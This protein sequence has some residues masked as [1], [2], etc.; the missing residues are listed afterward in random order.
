MLCQ[1]CGVE[2]APRALFCSSCGNK[3][4]APVPSEAVV[5]PQ[6]EQASEQIVD[7]TTAPIVE[8]PANLPPET[9]A[10][11]QSPEA[12]QTTETYAPV[13]P[14]AFPQPQ[15]N[16]QPTAFTPP[17]EYYQPPPDQHSQHGGY[18]TQ[19]FI[20]D[21]YSRCM[22]FLF[23]RP[24]RVWGL[25]LMCILMSMLSVVF[26]I[27]PIVFIPILLVLKLGMV[28]TF[29]KGIKGEDISS[30][31]LFEGFGK[32]RFLRNAGGM[33]WMALWTLIWMPVPFANIIKIYS[34]RFVPYIMLN[35]PNIPATEALKKS[36]AQTR[37]HKAMMFI[38]DLIIILAT[39]ILSVI[40]Y[41]IGQIP[42]I[43]PLLLLLYLIVFIAIF[44]FVI[45]VLEAVYYDKISKSNPVD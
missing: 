14:A 9:Q 8:Q 44:P 18:A 13:V 21:S 30:T 1:K 24:F 35:D 32:G 7:A 39:A 11:P 41:F 31:E 2:N 40:F 28:N 43:G 38:S 4:E 33:G 5:E 37:G 12:S 34:Y 45:G 42:H 10:D 36:M 23:R 25:T 20:L 3:L 22:S 6:M 17:P 26:G 19:G 27:L 15:S 16:Q 29:L